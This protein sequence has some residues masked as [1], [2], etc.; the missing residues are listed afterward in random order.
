MRRINKD[1]SL[2]NK[3]KSLSKKEIYFSVLTSLLTSSITMVLINLLYSISDV[4]VLIQT[5]LITYFG[6]LILFLK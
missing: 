4:G 2:I 3:D 5:G 6:M 1:K